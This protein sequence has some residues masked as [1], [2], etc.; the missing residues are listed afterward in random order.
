MLAV[1][2]EWLEQTFNAIGAR[3]FNLFVSEA[4]YVSD[5]I[6]RS[7]NAAKNLQPSGQRRL[8]NRIR[9]LQRWPAI[10]HAS[11]E[12]YAGDVAHFARKLRADAES[13]GFRKFAYDSFD[14]ID[15]QITRQVRPQA[16]QA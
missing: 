10:D 8:V 15:S 5:V 16:V 7:I 11:F 1:F 12:D 9:G 14:L 2:P 6:S 3:D 4:G 13:S